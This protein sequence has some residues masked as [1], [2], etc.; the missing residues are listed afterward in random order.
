PQDRVHLHGPSRDHDSRSPSDSISLPPSAFAAVPTLSVYRKSPRP[1]PNQALVD[2]LAVLR[3]W[4]FLQHGTGAPESIS[5]ATAISAI[6]GA[7]KIDNVEQARKLHKVGPKLLIKIDEFLTTG[8]IA[9][10]EETRNS[11]KFKALDEMTS[12][13]GVGQKTAVELY[14]NGIRSL[15]QMRALDRWPIGFKYQEDMQIKMSRADCESVANFI[16]IQLDR[17]E[18]GAHTV[19]LGGY[20]RGKTH[21]SD[22]DLLCTYPHEEGKEKGILSRLLY[23]LLAKGLIPEDGVLWSSSFASHNV[24]PERASTR[25][26]DSLDKAFVIFRHPANG[27]TRKRDYFRRVDIIITAWSTFGSAVV[28]WTGS[29]QFERDLRQVAEKKGYKFEAGGLFDKQTGVRIPTLTEKDV[30]RA[31][32]IP[33]L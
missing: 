15:E 6:I 28:G 11:A 16:R 20:R 21:S 29:T 19:L 2:E 22:I 12:V 30:F 26:F 33:W 4:R 1:C 9:E 13:Y 32:D 31:L 24:A 23:R 8:K 7:P 17:V 27:I 5:Y 25:S 18:P 10:S 14:E 3:S